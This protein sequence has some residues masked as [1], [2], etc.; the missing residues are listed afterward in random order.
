MQQPESSQQ[1]SQPAA[2]DVLDPEGNYVEMLSTA[3]L[4]FNARPSLIG[5]LSWVT[6]DAEALWVIKVVLFLFYILTH[7][8][9]TC[10]NFNFNIKFYLM[11]FQLHYAYIIYVF[12]AYSTALLTIDYWKFWN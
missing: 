10:F 12:T 2:P 8:A 3:H 7:F 1:T 5:F 4:W 6:L 11:L 9:L